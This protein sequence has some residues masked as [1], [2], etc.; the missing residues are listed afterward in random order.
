MLS[1]Q[2]K[3]WHAGNIHQES[4]RISDPRRRHDCCYGGHRRHRWTEC[5]PRRGRP[6]QRDARANRHPGSQRSDAQACCRLQAGSRP[7]GHAASR[8]GLALAGG[9][10]SR[11]DGTWDPDPD[12]QSWRASRRGCSR[13]GSSPSRPHK[14][15]DRSSTGRT[16]SDRYA[17]PSGRSDQYARPEVRGKPGSDY[18]RH[19]NCRDAAHGRAHPR[20]GSNAGH[21]D[22]GRLDSG[23]TDAS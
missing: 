4:D 22:A 19:A 16:A 14:R 23:C 10:R 5:R 17:A 1:G 20:R 6:P 12:P 18:H 2:A 21:T 11:Y 7:D 3:N 8:R 15:P 13:G 9:G